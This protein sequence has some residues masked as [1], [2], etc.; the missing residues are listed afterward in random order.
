MKG[1]IK[2]IYNLTPDEVLKKFNTSFHGLADEEAGKRLEEFGRNVIRKKARWK[3]LK[4]ISNQFNDILIWILLVAAGLALIFREYRDV[5]IILIIVF[6]NAVI[7]FIQEFKA[8]RILDSLK[9]LTKDKTFVIR[10][11]DKKEIDSANLVP[12]DIVALS[13]GDSVPAD[14]YLIESYD[15]KINSFIFTGESK[16]EKKYARV[17]QEENVPLAD[18]DNMVFMGETA[19]TGEG[20]FVV[21]GTGMATELGKLASLTQEMKDDLT[22]MQKQMRK[23]GKNIATLS[24]F[25]GILVM[26]AG[27]YFHLSLYENFLFAL[28]LAVSVVPEGLPAA[29]LVALSLGMKKLLKSNVLAKKLN[30]V[31]TLGSVSLIC[32]DKTGTIT[33]NELMVTKVIVN[34]QA[35]DV[36][37]EGYNPEGKFLINEKTIDPRKIGGLDLLFKIGTLCNNTSL[38]REDGHYKILGDPTEG[39]IIAA[40]KKYNPEDGIYELSEHKL[41]ENPFSSERM[42][43]SVIYEKWEVGSEKWEAERER[44]VNSYVKGSPDVMLDLCAQILDNGIA[45]NMTEEDRRNI[46]GIYNQMSSQALR[47]LSFAYRGLDTLGSLASKRKLSFQEGGEAEKDLIWVGMMAMIDPPKPDVEKA[48]RECRNLGIKVIMITGDYEITAKAI[49]E[50]VRLI[51]KKTEK[52]SNCN[53]VINGKTLDTLSDKEIYS[54]IR[55]GACVFARIA[56]EQKL[57]IASVLKKYKEVIAMTGDGVNDAPALKRADI[58][59][60]MG[61]IGTDVSKQASDMILLD[62]NFASIVK[63]IKEGRTIF[64]NLK[65]FVHY[66]FTSNAGELFSVTLGVLLGSPAPITAVQILS[67]DLATD[68]FPSF[69]LSAEPEEPAGRKNGTSNAKQKIMG[70]KGFRRIIYLGIIM[71]VGGVAAFLWSMIRG[72][73]YFGEDIAKDSL[74]YIKSTTAT[75]AVLAMSQMANLLQSRS[76]TLSPLK[77]G[78]FKNHFAI[79]SIFIALGILLLFMYVPFFQ[80]YL[81]MRPIDGFDW[82]MV[83]ATFAAIFFWEE[84]RKEEM[85]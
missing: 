10:G 22:P 32:T 84:A 75:Y 71:A 61:I 37:G 38:V 39:A 15:L 51:N 40:G 64:S 59:V 29:I 5:A 41:H 69:S 4:I 68:V 81:H 62:D 25:I 17:I 42:R 6:V 19:S 1:D 67:I 27:Q 78:F 14:G 20:K 63:G 33:K 52:L 83:A 21:T 85:K 31:E 50:Q 18:I 11:K 8:E 26:I 55:D 54:K 9:K 28:A 2:Q 77:L 76:E 60:A 79:F 7:G 30:A 49:A 12:G 3:W 16:P 13:A 82:I 36:T 56:P 24:V 70:W 74:L 47:V 73:W 34:N 57:R 45:R 23:L 80:Q 72:G 46:K 65:K 58:G 53:L 35:I 43:M 44:L 66:I 48:I